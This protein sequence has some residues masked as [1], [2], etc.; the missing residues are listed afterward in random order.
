[1]KKLTSML[2][3]SDHADGRR[4]ALNKTYDAAPSPVRRLQVGEKLWSGLRELVIFESA[5]LAETYDRAVANLVWPY[6]AQW[7]APDD[8]ALAARLERD[9][10][11][12]H[13]E[14]RRSAPPVPPAA[15]RIDEYS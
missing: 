7:R 10:D 1:M 8:R 15:P 11:W 6:L 9:W 14:P 3:T 13:R 12:L 2:G 5:L 4:I